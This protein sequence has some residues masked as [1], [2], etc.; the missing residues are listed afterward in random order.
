MKLNL[1]Q[2]WITTNN[3]D[4]FGG[5][6]LGTCWDLVDYQRR[7]PQL[8][9]GWWEAVQWS[10]SYNRLE[11]HSTIVQPG[12]TGITVFN[13]LAHHAQ[14]AGDNPTGLGHWSWIRLKGK[15]HRIT[16]IVALYR[17]CHSDG[18]LSTYQQHCHALSKLSWQDC[19]REAILSDLSSEVR[20][21]QEEGDGIIIPTDF[22][23]DIRRPWIQK[24]F[25]ELNLIEVLTAITD[26]PSTATHN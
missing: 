17:P 10:L 6:K 5:V 2:C 3:V 4:I 8:T 15:G 16:R 7:L 25:E 23:E 19:P 18:P 11:K 1:L 14:K 22:N 9:R 12:G 24:F 26:L 20:L 13:Q 21:W